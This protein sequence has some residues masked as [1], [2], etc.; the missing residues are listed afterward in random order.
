MISRAASFPSLRKC[1]KILKLLT[2]S[3][4]VAKGALN[5]CSKLLQHLKI[6]GNRKLSSAHSSGCWKTYLLQTKIYKRL[7]LNRSWVTSHHWPSFF[8]GTATQESY[9][10]ILNNKLWPDTHQ[11]DEYSSA[12]KQMQSNCTMKTR[13]NHGNNHNM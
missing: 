13:E 8:G 6:D 3:P 12:V 10:A 1:T 11:K 7:Y 5:H 4:V 2:F 9:L